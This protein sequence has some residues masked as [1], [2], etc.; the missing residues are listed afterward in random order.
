[1]PQVPQKKC[2]G[3]ADIICMKREKESDASMNTVCA[4]VRCV[5]YDVVYE[6]V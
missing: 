5:W 1:M 2:K 4:C 3:R 6:R